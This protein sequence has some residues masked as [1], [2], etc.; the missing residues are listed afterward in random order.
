MQQIGIVSDR[1]HPRPAYRIGAALTLACW[2]AGCTGL[3][4]PEY[5]RPEVAAKDSWSQPQG[6]TV[7]AEA[8]IQPDWW[9][10]FGDPYLNQL[11]ERAI[12]DN[13]DIRILA[14]R[15]GVPLVANKPLTVCG[16]VDS[17]SVP[18]N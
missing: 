2:L 6:V 9:T 7:S 16:S 18:G 3:G 8:T 13:I 17:G 14:A 4:G 5:Q 1:H 11:I 12:A 10:G 15:S